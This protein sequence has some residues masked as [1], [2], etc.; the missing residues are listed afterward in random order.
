MDYSEIYVNLEE[1]LMQKNE[2]LQMTRYIVV[3]LEATCWEDRPHPKE[4][5]AIEIGA[6]LLASSGGPV[7]SEFAEFIKPVVEPK[8]SDFCTQLTGQ[9]GSPALYPLRMSVGMSTA[10]KIAGIPLEGVHHR[11]ID[12]AKNIAKLAQLILPKLEC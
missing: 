1:Q 9:A 6:V 12:D 11:G 3:D 7:V 4:M 5:E 8:L 2:N 10:L